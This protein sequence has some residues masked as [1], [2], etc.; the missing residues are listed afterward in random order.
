MRNFGDVVV[1]GVPSRNNSSG[2]YIIELS[3][4]LQTDEKF[5]SNL[6]EDVDE[7]KTESLHRESL[8]KRFNINSVQ[9]SPGGRIVEAETSTL[10]VGNTLHEQAARAAE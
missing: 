4:Q 6:L 2:H 7:Y 3:S 8:M 1:P 9:M 5:L 10:K